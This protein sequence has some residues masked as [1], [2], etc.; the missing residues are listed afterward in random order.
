MSFIDRY[1]PPYL[2]FSGFQKLLIS[3]LAKAALVT[4]LDATP[5]L[6]GLSAAGKPARAAADSPAANHRQSQTRKTRLWSG[7]VF[8]VKWNL[9][10]KRGALKHGG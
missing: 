6:K 4:V 5:G 1:A 3:H 10:A 8:T 2:P 9:G 7:K